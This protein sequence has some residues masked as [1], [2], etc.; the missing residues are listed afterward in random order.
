MRHI[1]LKDCSKAVEAGADEIDM[2]LSRGL[3][4]AGRYDD[5]R[6]EIRE[7]RAACAAA[8]KSIGR[9]PVHLKIILET[10]ELGTLD[11]IRFASDLAIDAAT[12]VSGLP[13]LT[14][15]EVFIKPLVVRAL[16]IL[17]G[18]E[19]IFCAEIEG[20]IYEHPGVHEVAVF[21]V[22]HERLGEEV[23]V[24]IWPN[25]GAVF[26]ATD[27]WK[28]LDGK[29]ASYKVPTH[30]VIMNEENVQCER[31]RTHVSALKH[32]AL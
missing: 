24:A 19:N 21:G 15:G 5:V 32:A 22:P 23:A 25:E 10:G 17:R 28:L 1:R 4:L 7:T 30:V 18:G 6:R 11:S 2:V 31:R 9:D 16:Q 26:S 8:S 29:I 14:D 3:F 13:D 20:A 12:S 27:V